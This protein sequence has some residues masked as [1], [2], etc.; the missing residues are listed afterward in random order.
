[1]KSHRLEINHFKGSEDANELLEIYEVIQ[2]YRI[3]PP[4]TKTGRKILKFYKNRLLKWKTKFI[5]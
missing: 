4:H 1:M 5:L 2:Q 3:N